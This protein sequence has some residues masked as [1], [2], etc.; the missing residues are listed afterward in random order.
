MIFLGG[1]LTAVLVLGVIWG[2][3]YVEQKKTEK[4]IKSIKI[5]ISIHDEYDTYIMALMQE[6][7]VW[8]RQMEAQEGIAI[9]VDIQ[10]AGGSQITQNDQI[11]AFVV[12]GY[13][14]ICVGLV[15]RTNAFGIIDK[16][17]SADIPL[18]FFNREPVK[19]DLDSWNQVYYVGADA[20]QSGQMQGEIVIEAC[21]KAFDRIDK[22]QDGILQYIVLEGEPGHQDA[23]IRTETSVS[24]VEDAGY[25]LQ[26]LG[27][28]IANWNRAQAATKMTS[29]IEQFGEEIEVLF[30]NNDEMALGALDALRKS[31]IVQYPVIVGVDGLQ[32]G[33]ESVKLQE[34]AG[35]VYNDYRGQAEAIV[36]LACAMA[37]SQPIPEDIDILE[38]KYVYLPYQKVTY[39]NVQS[40]IRLLN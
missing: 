1:L 25:T 37:L 15:D 10:S 9:T 16:A 13:N 23:F 38:D 8:A 3:W 12:K 39:D 26:K 34:M 33:L 21:E 17:K 2:M 35:T 20:T 30:S 11:D 22:N 24:T 36:K 28:E 29:L 27:A 32:G 4:A 18:V 19:E 40:F 6:I 31:D 14:A 7:T 5:G